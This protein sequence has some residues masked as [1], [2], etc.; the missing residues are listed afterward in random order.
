MATSTAG[1][2]PAT[3]QR[4]RDERGRFV[5]EDGA[6]TRQPSRRV[7]PKASTSSK[8]ASS[9][10]ASSPRAASTRARSSKPGSGGPSVPGKLAA[11]VAV[12]PTVVVGAAVLVPRL[13][14][15]R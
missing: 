7:R 11:L 1:S 10:R 13:L 2:K 3:R 14:K 12:V 6:R 15:R 8:P 4:R 5:K 9:P